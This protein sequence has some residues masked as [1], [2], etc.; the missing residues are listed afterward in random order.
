MKHNYLSYKALFLALS[1]C[2]VAI[3]IGCLNFTSLKIIDNESF[4][5]DSYSDKNE[6]G[7]STCTLKSIAPLCY[8]YKIN[9]L[10]DFPY[11]GIYIEDTL[12]GAFINLSNFNQITIS[13]SATN[14][15]KIPFTLNALWNF[16][17]RPYQKLLPVKPE[18][19]R[20]TIPLNEF[21]TPDWWLNKHKVIDE[22]LQSFKKVVTINFEDCEQLS[23]NINDEVIISELVFST[24]N[25]TVY[26][27]I[28]SI[29]V[30]GIIVFLILNY[31]QK[32]RTL[33]PIKAIEYQPKNVTDSKNLII[34]FI[35]NNYTNPKLSL[36]DI[37][38]NTNVKGNDVSKILTEQFDLSFK[39]YLNYVRISEAKKL[40]KNSELNI[41]EIAYSVGY[42]NVTH[43]NRVFKN[44]E[45]ISPMEFRSN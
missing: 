45:N 27:T 16:K 5:I 42:N 34:T 22:K 15:S 30:V 4:F 11:A 2:S 44:S 25:S 23:P 24:D 10:V 43:F 32:N 37:S 29:W 6:T 21:K 19:S 40:L 8:K 18:V 17:K 39:E 31:I 7:E 12:E 14:A 13:I 41:S 26:I 35:G 1:I 20:F 9:N 38:R 33:I 3:A 36:Q 28:G